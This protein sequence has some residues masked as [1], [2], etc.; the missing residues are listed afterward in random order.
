MQDVDPPLLV[1]GDRGVALDH[2]ALRDRGDPGRART[3]S[4]P[5]PRASRRSR[6]RRVLLVQREHAAGQPLVLKRLAH[7]PAS[8]TGTPSSLKPAAPSR[9]SSTISVSSVPCWPRVIA[10]RKPTGTSASRCARSWSERST[11]RLVDDRVGVRHREHAAEAAGRRRARAGLEVLLVLAAGRAQVHVRIDEPGKD[12][13][14]LG[15]DDLRPVG[16]SIAPGAADLGDLAVADQQ[17]G[18]ARPCP[19]RGSSSQAERNSNSAGGPA[20]RAE[21]HAR[22]RGRRDA[23]AGCSTVGRS[24]APPRA[25][26][27]PPPESSS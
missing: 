18:A 16:G 4:R 24:R 25:S 3:S 11:G 7:A 6:Q 27:W 15:L 22:A 13:Q 9:A 1:A 20:A 5:R 23:H 2:R 26:S 19:A 21:A 10:A 8:A 12:V 14:A 17:V